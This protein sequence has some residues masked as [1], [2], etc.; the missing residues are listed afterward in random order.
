MNSFWDADVPFI[1]L[2][3]PDHLMYM[4]IMLLCLAGL[5]FGRRWV[6][7]HSEP[8]RWVLMVISSA[9]FVALYLWY[10]LETGFDLAEALP[11]HISRISTILGI[12]FLATK[13]L[14]VLDV[15]FYF[16]LF[17]YFT[18]LL[19]QRIYPITHIIGWSFLISH[20]MTI[21]LPIFAA[22]AYGWRPTIPALW[23]SFAWFL[24][25]FA[26]VLMVNPAVGGNY[27]YLRDRPIPFMQDLPAI[28]YNSLS[29]IVTFAIF[30]IGYG[31]SRVIVRNVSPEPA[32]VA[33]ETH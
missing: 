6:R 22:V 19:P 15:L 17:A 14:K 32:L 11:I 4:A 18:F 29:V 13:N 25:Y 30:W 10:G 3:G 5:I 20:I 24:L 2:F 9:Q 27:F 33:S 26:V 16:G 12:W 1:S 8:M 31:I 23:R 7:A 28:I 21:L